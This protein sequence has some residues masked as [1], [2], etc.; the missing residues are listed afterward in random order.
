MKC[1]QTNIA[2][3]S[4]GRPINPVPVW[5]RGNS[6]GEVQLLKP[7]I[8]STPNW[9]RKE[10][11]IRSDYIKH[12]RSILRN[13]YDPMPPSDRTIKA[14]FIVFDEIVA[15]LVSPATC[16]KPIMP[17]LKIHAPFAAD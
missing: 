12:G 3:A 11:S 4:R 10:N 6:T 14:S 9:P 2:G 8:D 7:R 15:A 1:D 5:Y 17:I 13:I 16:E